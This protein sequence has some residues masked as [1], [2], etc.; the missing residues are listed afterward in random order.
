[1]NQLPIF[2]T[3]ELTEKPAHWISYDTQEVSELY[4]G[5]R[6]T[7][8]LEVNGLVLDIP[9]WWKNEHPNT[10]QYFQDKKSILVVYYGRQDWISPHRGTQGADLIEGHGLF[11]WWQVENLGILTSIAESL[12]RFN[13]VRVSVDLLCDDDYFE[14]TTERYQH[15]KIFKLSVNFGDDEDFYAITVN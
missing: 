11:I 7:I 13:K 4:K 3:K 9:E 14:R 12:N 1:M 10:Y 5:D 2:F 15:N 6:Q 8:A